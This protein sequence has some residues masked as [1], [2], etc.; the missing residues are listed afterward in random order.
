VKKVLI[1]GITIVAVIALGNVL[2]V[3]AQGGQPPFGQNAAPT[4]MALVA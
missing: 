4:R 3:S 1:V 2:L